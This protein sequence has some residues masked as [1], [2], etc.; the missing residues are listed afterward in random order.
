MEKYFQALKNFTLADLQAAIAA[1]IADPAC[2]KWMPKP[3]ELIEKINK[4]KFN[5][6]ITHANARWELLLSHARHYSARFAFKVEGDKGCEIA[7]ARMGGIRRIAQASEWDNEKLKKEFIDN[8]I[9]ITNELNENQSRLAG[10]QGDH[11]IVD[12]IFVM[13]KMVVNLSSFE[14]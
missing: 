9:Q 13:P 1:H 6:L 12:D 2:G 8:Y 10:Y 3:A 11:F 4:S 7:V 14:V 5:P